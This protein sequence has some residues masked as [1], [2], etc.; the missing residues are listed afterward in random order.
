MLFFIDHHFQYRYVGFTDFQPRDWTYAATGTA[1]PIGLA[2]DYGTLVA[3]PATSGRY[4]AVSFGHAQAL[5]SGKLF[6]TGNFES[7]CEDSVAQ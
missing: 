4:A 5:N 6:L 2:W 7:M 3:C 1:P